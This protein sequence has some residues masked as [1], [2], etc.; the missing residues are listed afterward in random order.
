MKRNGRLTRRNQTEQILRE[1]LHDRELNEP[2]RPAAAR[3]VSRDMGG[4]GGERERGADRATRTRSAETDESASM[5]GPA[6]LATAGT[7]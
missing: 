6:E 2:A 5:I 3:P 4:A 1:I 7:S